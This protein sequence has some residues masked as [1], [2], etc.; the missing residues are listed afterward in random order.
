ME[1]MDMKEERNELRKEFK[2]EL[3]EKERSRK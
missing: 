1:I 2:K 3:E